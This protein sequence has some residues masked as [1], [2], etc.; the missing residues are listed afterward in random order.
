M[1]SQMVVKKSN[2][3]IITIVT[4]AI[5]LL[6]S[7][8]FLFGGCNLGNNGLRAITTEEIKLAMNGLDSKMNAITS[9]TAGANSISMS[10]NAKV[11][12]TDSDTS[13]LGLPYSMYNDEVTPTE[14]NDGYIGT[15]RPFMEVFEPI[16]DIINST[17]QAFKPYQIY[18]D[19]T[20]ENM[21]I[22]CLVTTNIETRTIVAYYTVARQESAG[23]FATNVRLELQMTEDYSA[24]EKAYF[25]SVMGATDHEI[26]AQVCEIIN[27]IDDENAVDAYH[28]L[29]YNELT[30]VNGLRSFEFKNSKYL[31]LRSDQLND[32]QKS[33][34][35]DKYF[36]T[37]ITYMDFITAH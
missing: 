13:Y 3:S 30:G 36:A 20:N 27:N 6:L 11:S 22:T 28:Y 32:T 31:Q 17:E 5:S 4:I 8:V 15:I 7:V 35:Y 9:G 37:K 25:L 2:K 23:I 16:V 19:D 26:Q 18:I 34:F 14:L 33:M 29:S 1:N 12:G 10:S 21:Y 24:W